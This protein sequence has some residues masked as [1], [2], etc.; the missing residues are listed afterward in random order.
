MN[1][2]LRTGDD[3]AAVRANRRR[4]REMVPQEPAWVRQV[5]GSQVILADDAPA[6]I[7]A[8]GSVARRAGTVCAVLV[9]DCM[10]VL[11]C[12]RT[13]T[14]IGIAHAGW[15]GLS[16]GVLENTLHAMNAPPQDIIA[17]LG[18]AIGPDAFEVGADVRDAFV[19]T[20]PD[21]AAAF[22]PGPKGK[23]FADL[24]TL[25][26]R[27]LTQCGVADIYG[28]GLCTFRDPER[29]YS[30]RRDKVTGR[31]AALIWMEP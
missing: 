5:H 1:L 15:R 31:M 9:A 4:L 29:F 14:C 23:W 2:G 8:D 19:A 22:R 17:W 27:R 21:A 3:D 6:D 7:E 30:Y 18:P 28:G 25:A 11:M 16:S 12:T 10:P 24:F 20:D 13:G 26:R